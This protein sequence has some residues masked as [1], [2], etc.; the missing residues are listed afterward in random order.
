MRPLGLVSRGATARF[1]PLEGVMAD[2]E[3]EFVVVGRAPLHV[4][5]DVEVFAPA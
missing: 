4:C 1:R 2:H 5:S 3:F